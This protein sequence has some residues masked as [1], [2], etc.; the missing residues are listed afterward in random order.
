MFSCLVNT[1]KTTYGKNVKIKLSESQFT[2]HDA[3]PNGLIQ[4]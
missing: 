4:G 2:G 1:P 3:A